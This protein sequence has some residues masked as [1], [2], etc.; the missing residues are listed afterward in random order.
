[1]L[2][3]PEYPRELEYLRDW[4]TEL[5]GKSGA[6]QFGLLPLSYTNLKA[7]SELKGIQ[8]D[9]AMLYPGDP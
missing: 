8:L 7:W 3:G 6:A 5:H 4:T 1:M 9:S 2:K